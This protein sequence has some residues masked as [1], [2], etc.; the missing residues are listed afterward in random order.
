MLSSYPGDLSK[1]IVFFCFVMLVLF[2]KV[3][4]DSWRYPVKTP[5]RSVGEK[6]VYPFWDLKIKITVKFT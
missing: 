1:I 6:V 2:P 4:R 3:C 5:P